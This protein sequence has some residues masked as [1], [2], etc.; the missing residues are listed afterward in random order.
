MR[1][2]TFT[3]SQAR[4]EEERW[5]RWLR[6]CEGEIPRRA[7]LRCAARPSSAQQQLNK[8]EQHSCVY[9][10]AALTAR[11]DPYMLPKFVCGNRGFPSSYLVTILDPDVACRDMRLADRDT[12]ILRMDLRITPRNNPETP[13]DPLQPL[14]AWHLNSNLTSSQLLS[15]SSRPPK[16][17]TTQSTTTQPSQ[18]RPTPL[19]FPPPKKPAQ[20]PT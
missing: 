9:R 8:N 12:V 5:A 2:N 15:P 18:K 6:L 20:S 3:D 1:I 4:G 11:H 19:Q 14:P 10:I 13:A 7:R 16:P 17:S